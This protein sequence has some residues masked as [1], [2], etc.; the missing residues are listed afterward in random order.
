M[1]ALEHRYSHLFPP[2]FVVVSEDP[3]AGLMSFKHRIQGQPGPGSVLDPEEAGDDALR[4]IVARHDLRFRLLIHR[5]RIF[6]FSD[7]KLLLGPP[8]DA[9]GPRPLVDAVCP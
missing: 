3:Y 8:A 9:Y 2:T 7:R 1:Q 6:K 4:A 5:N